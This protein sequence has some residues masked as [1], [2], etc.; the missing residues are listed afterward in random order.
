MI[1]IYQ[2]QGK[3]WS[4]SL[5]YFLQWAG[6][7]GFLSVLPKL[8]STGPEKGIHCPRVLSRTLSPSSISYPDIK[9]K[10]ALSLERLSLP[11]QK[12]WKLGFVNLTTNPSSNYGFLQVLIPLIRGRRLKLYKWAMLMATTSLPPC[13]LSLKNLADLDSEDEKNIIIF[14]SSL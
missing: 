10:R 4:L 2:L 13:D 5:L 14:L 8:L 9:D 11:K 1:G 3:P 12:A 7:W 6:E